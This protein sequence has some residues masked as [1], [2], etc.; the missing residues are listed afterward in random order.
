[1]SAFEIRI[2]QQAPH[3]TPIGANGEPGGH[4]D[5]IEP[6][7]PGEGGKLDLEHPHEIGDRNVGNL[8]A[9]RAGVKSRNVEQRPDDLL[10]RLERDVDVA[11]QIRALFDADLARALAER[12][13]VEPRGVERLQNIVAG[14]G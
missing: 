5:E 9:R 14:R 3:E 4:E 1:M 6:L 10:D 8:R 13:R 11:G 12:A 2:L 7:R